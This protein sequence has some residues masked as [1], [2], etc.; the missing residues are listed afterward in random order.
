[1]WKELLYPFAPPVMMALASPF[2][3]VNVRIG[4]VGV[5]IF[6]GIMLGVL[7]HLLSRVS[8]SVGI[9]QNWARF[10]FAV[11]PR[12]LFLLAAVRMTW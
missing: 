11:L 7:F 10:Y 2:A 12:V 1:M 4:G 5:K 9:I 8:S 6:S 3:H